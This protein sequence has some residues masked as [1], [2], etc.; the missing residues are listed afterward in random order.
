[1]V[2]F[3]ADYKLGFKCIICRQETKI[4]GVGYRAGFRPHCIN[5]NRYM[6]LK[7]YYVNGRQQ[8]IKE[9]DKI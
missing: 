5:C 9:Y 3:T 8:S 4:D 6:L 2:N 7:Y 1:M